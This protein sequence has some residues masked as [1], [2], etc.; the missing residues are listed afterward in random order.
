MLE[1]ESPKSTRDLERRR[2]V[3]LYDLIS[4][5]MNPTD[6]APL[7]VCELKN[8]I[9][10]GFSDP[11]LRPKYWKLFLEHYSKNKFKTELFLRTRRESYRF[12]M[13]MADRSEND[14]YRVIEN[15]MNR[16]FIKPAKA[17]TQDKHTHGRTCRF[18]D[19]ASI[20][21]GTSQRKVMERMLRIYALTNPSIGYVQGMHLVLAPI[22]YV[23]YNSEDVEDQKHSEEDA[24]FCFNDLMS[25]VGENFIEDLDHGRAGITHKMS[26]VMEIVREADGEL[27]ERMRSMGLTEG[28]FHMRWIMLM[29]VSSFEIDDVVWLWDRILSDAYRFEMV[30]YC[31][32]SIILVMRNIILKESFDSC[33]EMLQEPGMISVE[34]VFSSADVLRRNHYRGKE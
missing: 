23:L 34:T 4:K 6:P 12:Y 32:A 24:F 20:N 18:L 3:S 1:T 7:N 16:T 10:Y 25:E 8:Y 28:A 29:F 17:P 19:S 13:E 2:H 33:M 14:V 30:L 26:M 21:T 11:A 27:Y 5:Q 22:Y 15:D 31:C 9:Y